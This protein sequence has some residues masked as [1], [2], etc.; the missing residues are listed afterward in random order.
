MS[1]QIAVQMFS[2]RREF[3][4][5]PVGTLKKLRK[6]GFTAVEMAGYNGLPAAYFKGILDT[7]G[8]KAVA[9][10]LSKETVEN[11]PERVLDDLRTLETKYLVVPYLIGHFHP[12]GERFAEAVEFFNT[13][14]KHF[15]EKGIELLFH[16]HEDEFRY[17][18]NGDYNLDVLYS[19][20]D[21]E[22]LKAELD[23]G[24][25]SY[26]KVDVVKYIPKYN[27][28]LPVIHLK[29]FSWCKEGEKG[30]C[31]YDI[32]TC[33]LGEGD[34]DMKGIINAAKAAGTTVFVIEQDEPDTGDI[35]GCLKVGF[36][37]LTKLLAE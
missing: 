4:A 23:A 15:L 12:G 37:N 32:N 2:V 17:K 34:V 36:D 3:E 8:M 27:G 29:D 35:F 21:P 16:N 22:Y 19:S 33:A 18:T 13:M 6:I 7:L 5:D 26:A 28:R 20:T 11:D 31:R 14:G 30:N 24:W 1:Y 9:G 25:A 10:H